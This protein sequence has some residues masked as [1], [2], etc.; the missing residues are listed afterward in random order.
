MNTLHMKNGIPIN[1]EE[2]L[3][4]LTYDLCKRDCDDGDA[5]YQV[6]WEEIKYGINN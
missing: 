5:I 4:E 2:F 1:I 3:R 6:V